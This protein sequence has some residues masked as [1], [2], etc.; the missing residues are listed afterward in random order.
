MKKYILSLLTL[1]LLT[2]ACTTGFEELNTDPNRIDR[3]T[4][5]SLV[6]P[7][8]Y[9]MS[10]YFTVRNS[11][12]TNQL[13]QV[14]LPYAQNSEGYGVH[15]YNVSETAG[16]GTWNTCYTWL[17]NVREM[18]EAAEIYQQPIYQ[19]VATTLEAY[20]VGILT[21]SFG[22]IPYTEALNAEEGL[23]QPVFD[24]QKQV[25]A[26]LITKLEAAN[27]TYKESGT[28]VGNDLLYGNDKSK[29]QKF[30]NSLLLRMLLRT[31][32]KSDFTSFERLKAI[33][34]NP[35][36]YPIFTSNADAALVKITGLAPYDYAWGRRQDYTNAEA[37]S[38]F[39]ID[40][41]NELEDP[42]R[43]LFMTTARRVENGKETN[44]GYKG[45]V[46][47]HN[48]TRNELK[49]DYEP[50]TPNADLMV[51]TTLGTE[52]IEVIMSYAEVEFIKAEVALQTGDQAAA[53]T[54]YEKGVA[55]AITQWKGGVFPATYFNNP[56]AAF[57]GTLEQVLTQKYLALFFN[58]YQQ[59]FEYRRTGF[60]K[61]PKTQYML[62]DGVMPTR[63]MYH[64]DVRRFNPQNYKVAAERIGGDNVMTKVWWEK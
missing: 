12:F 33:L 56:K 50:S 41:L 17:R 20:I 64:N 48:P 2:T 26:T 32:K 31:S 28:M 6:T 16:N 35:S 63:F 61:L 54:A 40:L 19:A 42:R 60:P 37:M 25:Y 5:G 10:T 23:S 9:G 34:A 22:D 11:D 3:V 21:D 58:D 4:P 47:G 8:V 46:S 39:F 53:K 7:I 14:S 45:I 1:G 24:E 62:H 29:W 44:I 38:A 59:W 52:I 43:P 36:E 57:N 18:K 51:H 30:N 27:K 15:H 13:M 55:A 49:V